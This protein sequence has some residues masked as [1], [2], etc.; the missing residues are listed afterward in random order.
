MRSDLV[1]IMAGGIASGIFVRSFFILD[2]FLV[3]ALAVVGLC[4]ALAYR[5]RRV[6]VL[7]LF[8]LALIGF[9]LGTFRM[10]LFASGGEHAVL[11]AHVGERVAL[12]GEIV[13]EPDPRALRTLLTVRVSMVEGE[14]ADGLVLVSAERFPIFQY[15]DMVSVEGELT[16]PESFEGEFGRTFDYPGYLASRG[17]HHTV[18][19]ADVSLLL[20]G[21]GGMPLLPHLYTLKAH[22]MR[23]IEDALPEPQAGLAEG[24]T[25]GV[26]RA[27]GEDLEAAFRTTGIIHIVVLSGYNV[28]IVV[29]AVM[30]LLSFF[31]ALRARIVF[32]VMAIVAFAFLVG[33]SATVVRASLMAVLVLVARATGRT[34]EVT[35][36]L[37]IAALAMLIWNPSLLVHDPGFQLSFLATLGLILVGPLIERRLGLLPTRLQVREFVT[38]T[39]ATQLMVL[40][41]LLYSIGELSL[42]SVPVNVLVLVAVPAAM[43]LTF[44][45]AVAG[46][47]SGGLAMVVA[48]PAYLLLSYMIGVAEFFAALPFASV[49]VPAFPFWVVVWSY[50]LI[51]AWLWWM[52]K[53]DMGIISKPA[54][55][56]KAKEKAAAPEA[57]PRDP[58]PFR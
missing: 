52:L 45:T 2:L 37:V 22:F 4:A 15:G 1:Y 16:L 28:T 57:P 36:A 6:R 34:Y 18:S 21:E 49:I 14:E 56:E 30:R 58:L 50:L 31:F 35:R 5:T 7:L 25:L 42:V 10:D 55:P 9:A 24:L 32:G 3:G 46:F 19:F 54:S 26:K 33:L 44:F 27:L 11:D 48:Y 8:G 53:G 43:L 17:I 39:L 41:V 12:V 51:A 23:S 13:R 38:A 20:R 47:V 29:E 40:P